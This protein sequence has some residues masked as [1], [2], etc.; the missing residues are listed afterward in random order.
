[1][2]TVDKMDGWTIHVERNDDAAN[3]GRER[4]KE[5]CRRKF[6]SFDLNALSIASIC[7]TVP[8]CAEYFLTSSVHI[9][10]Y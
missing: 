10:V 4:E 9:K 5:I 3:G 8:T 6:T 7:G 1:M 2:E